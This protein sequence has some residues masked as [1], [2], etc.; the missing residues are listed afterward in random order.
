[1]LPLQFTNTFHSV[2]SSGQIWR[3]LFCPVLGAN[4]PLQYRNWDKNGGIVT[5]L[6]KHKA[7]RG[8]WP[9][10]QSCFLLWKHPYRWL[11]LGRSTSSRCRAC[12]SSLRG[13]RAGMKESGHPLIVV[14]WYLFTHSY[15]HP[16]RDCC[17]D[18][19]TH[20]LTSL[21]WYIQTRVW[22]L[23]V[24]LLWIPKFVICISLCVSSTSMNLLT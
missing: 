5:D 8:V 24:G 10:I 6:M 21:S 23:C 13:E 4:S 7:Q 16:F 19:F 22:R 20:P 15:I 2:P 17:V 18:S 11:F 3:P 12:R 1:M 14:V 9:I